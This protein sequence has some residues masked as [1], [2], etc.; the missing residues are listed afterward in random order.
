MSSY[1]SCP[2]I[3]LGVERLSFE[4]SN[5]CTP[6]ARPCTEVRILPLHPSTSLRA[7]P[8]FIRRFILFRMPQPFG[9]GVTVRTS[10]LAADGR[11]PLP[12]CLTFVKP[13]P[14]LSSDPCGPAAA[15]RRAVLS[16]HFRHLATLPRSD[17]RKASKLYSIADFYV[18]CRTIADWQLKYVARGL[19]R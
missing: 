8:G 16:H 11:Y 5:W 13:E 1:V 7:S 18:M 4:V 2:S 19:V 12:F 9:I 14:G 6:K 3:A 10:R 15:L 17:Q